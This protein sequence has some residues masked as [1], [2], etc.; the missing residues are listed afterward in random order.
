MQL[1]DLLTEAMMAYQ[2]TQDS[3]EPA[4]ARSSA[5]LP[6]PQAGPVGLDP[7]VGDEPGYPGPARHRGDPPPADSRRLGSRWDMPGD[8]P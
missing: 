7:T 2:S 4:G 5:E 3:P 1:A 8:R 6:E